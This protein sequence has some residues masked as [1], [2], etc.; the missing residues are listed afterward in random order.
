MRLAA[1]THNPILPDKPF[2]YRAFGL[3]IVSD[4]EL[5]EL[6]RIPHGET[7]L[8][9]NWL[10]SVTVDSLAD[11]SPMRTADGRVT[12]SFARVAAFLIDA[13]GRQVT[14]QP[15]E[16]SEGVARLPLLG[17]VMAICL[18]LDRRLV[19]HGSGVA[20]GSGIVAFVGDKGA[21]KSTTAAASVLAGWPL[22][23][24]DLLVCGPSSDGWKAEATYAQLKLNFDA[25]EA[26]RLD[27][28]DLLPSPHA[29]FPKRQLRLPFHQAEATPFRA[30]CVLERSEIFA[31]ER[32]SSEL[33]FAA[34][35]RFAY[36]LR[37]ADLFLTGLDGVEHF[38]RC[39]A[40]A[41]AVPIYTLRVP[42]TL[43]Q[44][45]LAVSQLDTGLAEAGL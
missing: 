42:P 26:I 17:P 2:S 39:A 11:I 41:Q 12:L 18:H 22:V 19:L 44:L 20:C 35:L 24:D 23:S 3:R 13:D 16:G 5:P 8:R 27:Q 28:G 25:A 36:V 9:V 1:Q 29:N 45:R 40:F 21:G 34:V 4:L 43:D 31:L 30:L 37:Y 33:S 10:K 32:L 38:G 14:V 15:A 6:E 7:D